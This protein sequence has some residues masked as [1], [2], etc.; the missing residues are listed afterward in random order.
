MKEREAGQ[1]LVEM[2]I[3]LPLLLLL[4]FGMVEVGRIYS[5]SLSMNSIARDA[6]RNGAVGASDADIRQLIQD[7][8]T[9]LVPERVTV[10]V[11]PQTS[12]RHRGQALTVKINY[13]LPIN[14]PV[15]MSMLPN[16]FP[17][18]AVCTMRI[19]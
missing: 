7:R 16:P 9:L 11:I 2:A 1:A 13:L 18:Q 5:T 19:E 6:A 15:L 4:L 10:T 8:G 14:V 12:D 17:L 3:V